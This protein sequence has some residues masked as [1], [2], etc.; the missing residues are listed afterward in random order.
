MHP[1]SDT[2]FLVNKE[3]ALFLAGNGLAVPQRFGDGL[4]NLIIGAVVGASLLLLGIA[5]AVL[6]VDL[7]AVAITVIAAASVGAIVFTMMMLR[8]G[9]RSVEK[10][11]V[12]RTRARRVNARFTTIELVDAGGGDWF[13]KGS[14]AFEDET[15]NIRRGEFSQ[16]RPDLVGKPLPAGG[17]PALVLYIDAHTYSIL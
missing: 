4:V 9:W 1:R 6:D 15:G 5:L 13:L 14:Y 2:P 16:Y 7:G 17:S 3:N 12:Y 8:S 10:A 11:N